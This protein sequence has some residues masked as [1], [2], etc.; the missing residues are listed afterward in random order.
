MHLQKYLRELKVSLIVVWWPL[1]KKK[2]KKLSKVILNEVEV[3]LYT[4]RL[5]K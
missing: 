1:F 4:N 5:Q 3:A 2:K